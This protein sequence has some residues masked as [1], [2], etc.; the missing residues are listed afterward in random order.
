M[1]VTVQHHRA[2]LLVCILLASACPP[3][4]ARA[5]T[6]LPLIEQKGQ[7]LIQRGNAFYDAKQFDKAVVEYDAA[8]QLMEAPGL[9]FNIAQCYRQ[10]G[11]KPKA[12]EHYKSFIR[13]VPE[14]KTSD[15]AREHVKRLE[16]EVRRDEEEARQL[17]A[18]RLRRNSGIGL[19]VGGV[20]LAGA[21]GLLY[22]LA[23]VDLNT[24]DSA[25]DVQTWTT[26]SD[27][28]AQKQ[29]AAPV[30]LGIGAAAVIGGIVCLA[31]PRRVA[32]S[33]SFWIAPTGSGFVAGGQ[34]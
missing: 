21:G 5:G 32:E 7:A 11:D 26:R 20:L 12:L 13:L 25:A 27:A 18:A 14:G 10:K 6:A 23:D 33:H 1:T 29:I 24:A 28:A 9:L 8:Y 31:L 15:E 34:F 3:S 19:T 4:I 30:M 16:V 22:Y 17:R 2:R